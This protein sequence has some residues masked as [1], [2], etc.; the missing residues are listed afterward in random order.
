M[1]QVPFLSIDAADVAEYLHTNP[2]TFVLDVRTEYEWCEG[3]IAGATRIDISELVQRWKEL[4]TERDRTIV[5]ICAV[6]ARSAAACEF[7]FRQ[8]YTKMIN[9]D[10]GMTFYTGESVT[11]P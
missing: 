7:L 8:G 11:G 6:G 4:P 1:D 5:C 2:G 3:H 9:V 10:G